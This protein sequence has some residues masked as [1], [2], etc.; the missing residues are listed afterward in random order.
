MVVSESPLAVGWERG[1][2]LGRVPLAA[3]PTPPDAQGVFC[4]WPG[5]QGA[6]ANSRSRAYPG[7]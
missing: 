4:V 7:Q 6:L 3:D 2:P 5:R 1:N